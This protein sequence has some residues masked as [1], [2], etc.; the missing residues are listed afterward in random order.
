MV[1]GTL[2]Q[3]PK[4]GSLNFFLNNDIWPS[5]VIFS[6]FWLKKKLH[7]GPCCRSQFLAQG[8]VI[9]YQISL[10]QIPW[11]NLFKNLIFNIFDQLLQFWLFLLF[12]SLQTTIFDLGGCYSGCLTLSLISYL[13]MYFNFLKYIFDLLRPFFNFAWK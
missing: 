13:Q 7:F 1:W 5:Y 2:G 6:F 3:I 12:C 11:D 4:E 9:L 10:D 8:A